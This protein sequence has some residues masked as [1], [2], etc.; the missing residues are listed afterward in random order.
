MSRRWRVV[1]A[2]V[3]LPIAVSVWWRTGAD[4]RRVDASC[5]TWLEH[6][7]SLR[8]AVSETDEAI[9]RAA[10]DHA[11]RIG[12]YY[13]DVDTTRAAIESWR[14]ESPGVLDALDHDRDASRLER[15]AVSSLEE[16]ESGVAE[17]DDLIEAGRPREVALWLPEL[18]ARFQIVDD[19]CL[20]AARGN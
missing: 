20:A 7:E 16:V 6:R 13:N 8:T 19:V 2:A 17:L 9:G 10:A 3:L 5:D 11:S 12:D 1:G 15:G 4:E 14:A 18:D